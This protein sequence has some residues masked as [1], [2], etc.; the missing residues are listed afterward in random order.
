MCQHCDP[1]VQIVEAESVSDY[2]KRYY[3]P[4][5]LASTGFEVL[6]RAY[7]IQLEV[8]GFVVTSHY[9]NVTGGLIAWPHF[10]EWSERMQEQVD[11]ER[12]LREKDPLINPS[13]FG[14]SAEPRSK[15]ALNTSAFD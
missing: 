11:R 14:K 6:C 1:N 9:D 3:K 13:A 5:R 7:E 4:D 10:E 8:Y 12:E 15:P 2:L